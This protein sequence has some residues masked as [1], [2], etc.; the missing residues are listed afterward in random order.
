M[1]SRDWLSAMSAAILARDRR[2]IITGAAYSQ[3]VNVT[4][5]AAVSKYTTCKATYRPL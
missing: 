3:T 5:A 4:S 2:G 1:D